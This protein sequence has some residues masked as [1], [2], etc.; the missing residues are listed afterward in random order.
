MGASTGLLPQISLPAQTSSRS[1]LPGWALLS[2]AMAVLALLPVLYAAA[3]GWFTDPLRSIGVFLPVVACVFLLRALKEFNGPW[4]GTSR[5]L[6]LAGVAISVVEVLRTHS[7]QIWLTPGARFDPLPGGLAVS[8]LLAGGLLLLG[9]R[10]LLRAC[11]FPVVLFGI[12]NPVP[13]VFSERFDLPLQQASAHAARGFAHLIHEFPTGEQLRLMFTP[14]FGMFIAP[15]CNGI[16]GAITLAYL[17][18]FVAAWRRLRPGACAGFFLAGMVCGYLFNFLRLFVLVLYYKAGQWWPTIQPYGTGVDYCIGAGLFLLAS[19][20]LGSLVLAKPPGVV[21]RP[22]AAKRVFDRGLPLRLALFM[23][24]CAVPAFQNLRA[25]VAEA[26]MP[27]LT[28][29]AAN[30]LPQRVGSF[31]LQRE[32]FEHSDEGILV[33]HWGAYTDGAY[34]VAIGLWLPENDHDVRFS[35]ATRGDT[36]QTLAP[37]THAVPGVG[38]VA[39]NTFQ[40]D[41]GQ[42]TVL[43]A[44][45]VCR[46]C[47]DALPGVEFVAGPLHVAYAPP[48]QYFRLPPPRSA[49]LTHTAPVNTPADM[50]RLPLERFVAGLDERVLFHARR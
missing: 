34:G 37:L 47:G 8:L 45:L 2:A 1:T 50:M 5:G 21:E 38:T 13:H 17:C 18:L 39:Y 33:Y 19:F 6:V 35:H 48:V 31:R 14:E 36:L 41:E 15:G 22:V 44:S 40:Y 25:V 9:G 24:L 43:L 10:Q 46:P 26:R 12:T 28:E 23:L 20:V 11:V 42:T 4:V 49:V 7:V 3:R 32:W 29:T 16:R 27:R 30:S